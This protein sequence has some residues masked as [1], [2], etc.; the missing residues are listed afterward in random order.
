MSTPPTWTPDPA[1]NAYTLIS[2]N[3]RCRVWYTSMENWAAVISDRGM[4]SAAY[5][6]KTAEDAKAWCERQVTKA[7][8]RL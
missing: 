8:R 3:V 7:D 5:N 6:F 2:D 4:S 1:D